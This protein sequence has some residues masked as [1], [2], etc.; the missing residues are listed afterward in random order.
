[1]GVFLPRIDAAERRADAGRRACFVEAAMTFVSL[2]ID[3][4]SSP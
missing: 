4:A 3:E 1:M 2:T